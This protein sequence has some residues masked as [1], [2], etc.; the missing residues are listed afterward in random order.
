MSKLN[1]ILFARRQL[2]SDDEPSDSESSI[3]S[4]DLAHIPVPNLKLDIEELSIDMESQKQNSQPQPPTLEQVLAELAN[5]ITNMNTTMQ[6]MSSKQHEQE[7]LLQTLSSQRACTLTN[8]ISPPI[9]PVTGDIFRIPDPIKSI[10][11]YDGSRKQLQSWIT[12]VENTL[13][14][15]KDLVS[16]QTYFI[17]VQAVLNKITGNAKDA[18]CLAGNPLNFEDVKNILVETFG[19]RQ[20]LATYKAQL[21]ANK[22]NVDM[23]IHKYYKRTKEI[24]QNIKAIAR[25]N[26]EY[27]AHWPVICK[28]ID[29]DAL[30][31]FIAGL[32]HPYFGYAQA[33]RPDDIESAYAFLCKFTSAEKISATQ[34]FSQNQFK[35]NTNQNKTLSPNDT[36]RHQKP[37]KENQN[38]N[39]N[40]YLPNR[41]FTGQ[42]KTGNQEP[43]SN[44]EQMEVD[45]SIRSRLTVNRKM[46]NNQEICSDDDETS[47]IEANFC[48]TSTTDL[49]T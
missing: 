15:F 47:D 3:D 42:P 23:N 11:T 32:K 41:S 2:I 16:E 26:K 46:V 25:Q 28:F 8:N 29:E 35:H 40:Q 5:R 38:A 18:I 1:K 48:T 27:N 49:E 17:Y 36:G 12:T 31:A 43:K 10:P 7:N 24:V 22:Q 13:N 4:G 34:Q 20:E 37:F 33:A 45:P 9:P 30:A 19:D 44:I 21:W 39:K 6:Q 14:V